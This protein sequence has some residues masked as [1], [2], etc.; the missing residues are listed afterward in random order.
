LDGVV[1]AVVAITAA[2]I[3]LDFINLVAVWSHTNPQRDAVLLGD[4]EECVDVA[5]AGML[6]DLRELRRFVG[7]NKGFH[8]DL[9]SFRYSQ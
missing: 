3:G 4:G 8:A 5:E 1:F 2:L 7:K 9:L 6:H